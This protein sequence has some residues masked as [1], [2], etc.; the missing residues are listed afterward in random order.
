MF[1]EENRPKIGG[2]EILN[3]LSSST[4][5]SSGY[6]SDPYTSNLPNT[7]GKPNKKV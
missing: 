7:V 5:F 1:G 4:G 2:K 6:H 3:G